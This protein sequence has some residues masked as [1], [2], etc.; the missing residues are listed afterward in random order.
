MAGVLAATGA[1]PGDLLLLAAGPRPTVARALD[2][3]RQYLAREVLGLVPAPGA[4]GSAG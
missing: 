1:Q 3:V 4:P 2:R